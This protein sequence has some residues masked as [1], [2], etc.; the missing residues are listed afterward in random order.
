MVAV[1]NTQKCIG[2]LVQV[3]QLH[4]GAIGMLKGVWHL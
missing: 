1:L 2:R 3:C 4:I